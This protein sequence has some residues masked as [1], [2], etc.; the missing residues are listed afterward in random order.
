M[1]KSVL[2]L[3]RIVVPVW[4][5][6]GSDKRSDVGTVLMGKRA[7]Y[8]EKVGGKRRGKTRQNQGVKEANI[9]KHIT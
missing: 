6:N 1:I 9:V 7:I 8:V 4:E 3:S 5:F 2:S